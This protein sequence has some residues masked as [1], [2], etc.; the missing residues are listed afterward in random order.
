MAR[1]SSSELGKSYL[2]KKREL[3]QNILTPIRRG[4][5]SM[6]AEQTPQLNL[7]VGASKVVK[8]ILG[9]VDRRLIEPAG[10]LVRFAGWGMLAFIFYLVRFSDISSDELSNIT[11]WMIVYGVYLLILE[12]TRKLAKKFYDLPGFR[13]ARVAVNLIMVSILVNLT[14]TERHLLIFTFTV[15]IFAAVVYFADKPWVKISVFIGVFTGLLWATID[16]QNNQIARPIQFIIYTLLL[17][18]LSLGFE[19]FRKRV[20]LLPSRLTELARELHKTLDLQQ[21]MQEILANSIE[22]AQAQRGLIVIVNP[23]TKKYV[24]HKLVNFKLK[25]GKSN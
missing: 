3:S 2:Y 21:L 6:T 23:R 22:I 12:A 20:Y 7:D 4:S 8:G 15:P 25:E 10:T 16:S 1:N 17:V 5:L 11:T 18:I 14:E 13:G 9:G 24:S 19:V